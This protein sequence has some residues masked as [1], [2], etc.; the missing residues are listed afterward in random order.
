MSKVVDSS[1]LRL[2][3]TDQLRP[4]DASTLRL[5]VPIPNVSARFGSCCCS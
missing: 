2:V 5:G 4:Y 1:G 3:V